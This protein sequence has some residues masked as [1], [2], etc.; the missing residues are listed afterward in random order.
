MLLRKQEVFLCGFPHNDFDSCVK[1]RTSRPMRS[2]ATILQSHGKVV[3]LGLLV[4]AL[5]GAAVWSNDRL[6]RARTTAEARETARN[7]AMIISASL[8]SE[9]EK[10]SLVPLVLAEDPQ[11]RSLLAG[12]RGETAALDRR[13]EGLA[14]QTDAAVIYLMDANGVTLAAS[15]WGLPTTFVG[16]DYSFRRYFQEAMEKGSATQF[17][18][19]TVSRKPGLYIAQLVQV[20]G[21]QLGVVAVKVEFDKLEANWRAATHGV[22]V[23]DSDGVILLAS[24]EDWRFRTTDPARAATRDRSLDSRQ[25]GIGSLQPLDLGN[26]TGTGGAVAAPLL[27]A[28]QPIALDGWTLHLLADPTPRIDAAVANAR[29]YLL[30]GIA[31]A[32]ILAGFALVMRRRRNLRDE[33]VLAERTRTLRE[34]LNQANRLATLGQ[35]S[36]GVGHEINQPVAAVRLLAEN[37]GRLLLAGRAQEAGENFKRIAEL[38]DR[39]GRI[40]AELRRF[41]RRDAPEPEAFPLA[42][43][44]EGALLLLRDRIERLGISLMTPP[45]S[46]GEIQVRAE[47]V[48]LEQVLVNLL[49]NALDAAGAGGSV[50]L[51]VEREAKF[52]R[53]R[54]RDTGPGIDEAVRERLF[55]PF[56]TTKRNGL[57]LGLVISRDIMRGLG[58]DLTLGSADEGAEFVMRIPRA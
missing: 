1:I 27:D 42:A 8:Q 52:C 2:F 38:T 26:D 9:L 37:G 3:V 17:A 56:A 54:V 53:L 40:T 16:S 49:Q 18:L 12:A 47:P 22:F 5:I 13:L 25:F 20:G 7:E 30:L 48:R 31:L 21:K 32:G 46:E 28:E 58:G 50:E 43:A 29:L 10:F 55:Q 6:A 23:T 35:V 24:N 39:M 11:V 51:S 41:A 14:R 44:I 4:A 34:Q 33:A 19:G 15:N 45:P 36:A 57:G